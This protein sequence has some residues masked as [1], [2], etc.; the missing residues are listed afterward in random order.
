MKRWSIVATVVAVALVATL[1]VGLRASAQKRGEPTGLGQPQRVSTEQLDDLQAGDV[2]TSGFTYQGV[3]KEDGRPVDG[4]RDM[5][6]RLYADDGCAAMVGSPVNR[7]VAVSDGLFD[8]SL[9][10]DPG[11]YSGQ[12]L[13]LET[14][15]EGTVIG[16]QPIQTVPYASGLRPGAT[17]SAAVGA[18][19][20]LLE[21]RSGTTSADEGVVGAKIGRRSSLG[22]PVGVYGYAYDFGSTGVWGVS[23]SEFGWGVNG[24]ADGTDSIGVRGIA[25]A[26]TSST[27]GVY[28]EANSPDGYAGYFGHTAA[29]GDGVGLAAVGPTG[30]VITGTDGTGLTVSASG[31]TGGD[32]G[33]RGEHTSGDGVVGFSDGP[34]DLDNGV[35]GFTN[36]GY[37]VYGFSNA[38][39]QYAG[40]FGG[41][42]SV[43]G[44]TGCTMSYVANNG[45]E[46]DLQLGDPV[47]IEGVQAPLAGAQQ[48]VMEVARAGSGDDVLGVVLGRTEI[49]MVE[50]GTDDAKP[51]AHLGPTVGTA[52]PG[53]Y[54]VVVVQGM[55]QVRVGTVG[56]VAA[57]DQVGA[58]DNGAVRA[59]DAA[60]FGTVL[61]ESEEDGLV[62]ALVGFD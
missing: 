25:N 7:T 24:V 11:L 20:D 60:S 21:V 57:G 9:A 1:V 45:S 50:P 31:S 53:D 17:I 55:A 36:G 3:L 48:P 47:R 14:E 54:L 10:F 29:T 5:T 13:W 12:A 43:E 39:G 2:V 32:D 40:Y 58:G 59:V 6:F 49:T 56:Q 27:Y 51:G 33:L 19:Q 18:D 22:Y 8:A 23:D 28:G 16:C 26:F 37:G 46:A 52:E 30:A 35:I 42:I 41:P 44:C 4:M 34:G 62:W 38:A 15:V 61:G